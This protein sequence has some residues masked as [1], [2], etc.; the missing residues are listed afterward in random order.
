MY[1]QRVKRLWTGSRAVLTGSGPPWN[2]DLQASLIDVGS[3][4]YTH[5]FL[6]L[7]SAT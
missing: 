4:T 5:R 6:R 2:G 7:I 3:R 1:F